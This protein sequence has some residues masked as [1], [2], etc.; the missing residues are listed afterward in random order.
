VGRLFDKYGPVP[1]VI[2]GAALFSLVMWALVFVQQDTAVWM[3]LV[4]HI[5]LSI[6]LALMFTPL[7]TLSLG[8]LP[9]Q[10]YSHGSAMIGTTQQVG[11]AAGTALFVAIMTF[12]SAD[13]AGSGADA[14]AS[15]TGGIRLAFLCGAVISLAAVGAACLLRKP[16]TRGSRISHH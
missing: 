11:G 9:P 8:A 3:L 4:A 14:L 10:L 16:G 1:L 2:P 12:R 15:L 7:F 6:G 13:L 5:V